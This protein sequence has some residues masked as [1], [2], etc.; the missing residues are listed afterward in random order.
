MENFPW[1]ISWIC[2]SLPNGVTKTDVYIGELLLGHKSVREV[3]ANS[4]ISSGIVPLVPIFQSARNRQ[5]QRP[6]TKPSDEIIILTSSCFFPRI[7]LLKQGVMLM[8]Q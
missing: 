6:Y 4:L 7:F 3:V 2:S 5:E 1:M 8:A